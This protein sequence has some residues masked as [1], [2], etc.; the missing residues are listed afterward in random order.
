MKSFAKLHSIYLCIV[1]PLLL[2]GCVSGPKDPGRTLKDDLNGENYSSSASVMAVPVL[3][4]KAT[5]RKISGTIFCGEGL[6]QT[7]ANKA[8]V[9]LV[10]GTQ[11]LGSASTSSDGSYSFMAP[12][13]SKL[14]YS[15]K[16]K[17][18]CG[19]ASRE[20]LEASKDL[21]GENLNLK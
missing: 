10:N 16:A 20:L 7:L 4:R 3:E 13:N 11:T 5:L 18:S 2:S 21:S 17:A 8:S 1:L 6:A 9:E 12:L 19:S 14:N 15:L